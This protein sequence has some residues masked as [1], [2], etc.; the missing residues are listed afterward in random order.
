MLD[1]QRA[2]G[3]SFCGFSLFRIITV[4]SKTRGSMRGKRTLP[5]LGCRH[6]IYYVMVIEGDFIGISVRDPCLGYLIEKHRLLQAEFLK[7]HK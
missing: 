5:E 1:Q 6:L 7:K 3:L 2:A 4:G